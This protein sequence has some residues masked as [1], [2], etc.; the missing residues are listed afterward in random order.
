MS[1]SRGLEVPS[2]G[3]LKW[4]YCHGFLFHITFMFHLSISSCTPIQ[5]ANTKSFYFIINRQIN[6]V[7]Q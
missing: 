6:T 1:Y 7:I 5:K 2:L 3:F 4:K